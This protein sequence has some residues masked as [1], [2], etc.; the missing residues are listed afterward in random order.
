LLSRALGLTLLV[1]SGIPAI[2]AL[3]FMR[4]ARTS[5]MPYTTTH[6]L[7]TEGPFG[8]SRNPIYVT[9]VLV[10]AALAAFFNSLWMALTLPVLVVVLNKGVIERE[11]AYL[12]RRFGDAYRQYCARVPRW[13]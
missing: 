1:V 4:R 3:L 9:F 6:A 8:Y 11:E 7:V 12:V 13:L 10:P 2:S 5:S